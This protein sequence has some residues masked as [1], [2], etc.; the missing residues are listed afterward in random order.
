MPESVRVVPKT[1]SDNGQVIT[2]VVAIGS[3]RQVCQLETTFRTQSR[4]FSYLHKTSYR[5]RACRSRQ[6]RAR[7]GQ[8][9]RDPAHD[10]LEPILRSCVLAAWLPGKTSYI[11]Q[12][13]PSHPLHQTSRQEQRSCQKKRVHMPKI[14]SRS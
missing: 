7:R 3:V 10:A 5:V 12:S 8:R 11:V 13:W 9:R 14:R 6:P 4:A 2:F 1:E